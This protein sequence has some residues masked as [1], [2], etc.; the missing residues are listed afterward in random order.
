M[1][2]KKGNRQQKLVRTIAIILAALLAAGAIVSAIVSM[3]YAEENE[4]VKNEYAFSIEYMEDEQALRISQR[5][6]YINETR[7]RLDRVIF[8]APANMMRRLNAIMYDDGEIADCF[9][10]GYVPGGIDLIDVRVNGEDADYGFQGE[11][12]VFLRV[13]CDLDR[14]EACEFTFD[15]YLLL[16]ENRAFIGVNEM[17]VQ[18]SDFYFI[19]ADYDDGQLEFILNAP[20][21]HTRYIDTNPADYD[22]EI[23]LP[24][25]DAIA[26]TGAVTLREASESANEWTIHADSARGFMLCFGRRYR[27][28]SG[29]SQS[30]VR[31]GCL[32]NARGISDDVIRFAAQAIDALETWF[33]AYPVS[34]ID[35]VQADIGQ[36]CVANTGCVWLSGDVLTGDPARLRHVLW[37][38]LAQQYFGLS[39]C[40]RPVSD[41]WLSDSICEYIAYLLTE[42]IDGHEAYLRELN[43]CIV[44]SLQLTVPGGLTV[45]SEA[46]L[47][48]SY[49]YDI[50]VRDRGAAVFHELS[51]A[52]GRDALIEGFRVFYRKGLRTHRLTEMD[53]ADAMKEASGKSWESFLTD[54]L[55]NVD[56]YVNQT[57]DWLD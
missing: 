26:A 2:K 10:Y 15:Y 5:L 17:D 34:D 23:A 16:T 37:R 19:A 24:R 3:A 35:I 22:A 13:A 18:L 48:S 43:R 45:T 4:P 38:A 41:A 20:I 7:E 56:E 40:A 57:I 32:M 25:N 12:E 49:E 30:G 39:V 36:E 51:V 11:N 1:A 55:F 52:M 29:M 21:A 14:G 42:E 47:F 6:V 28:G 44:P 9:P 33:G 46:S 8:Y 50:V 53:L 31:I 27:A 54:W